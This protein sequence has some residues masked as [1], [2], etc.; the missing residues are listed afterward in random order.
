[1]LRLLFSKMNTG[2]AAGSWRD[3]VSGSRGQTRSRQSKGT[4]EGGGKG[5]V[6]QDLN[7]GFR[8]DEMNYRQQME[9]QQYEDEEGYYD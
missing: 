8:E 3:A 9:Q 7:R 5:G 1:M 2:E 4:T 6:N